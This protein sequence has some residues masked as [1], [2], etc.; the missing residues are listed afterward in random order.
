MKKPP[1]SI[2]LRAEEGEA[3]IARDIRADCVQRTLG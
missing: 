3:L 2:T 1:A